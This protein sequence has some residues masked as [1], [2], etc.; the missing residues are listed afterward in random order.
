MAEANGGG[1]GKD[2]EEDLSLITSSLRGLKVQY[3]D[4]HPECPVC[5]QPCLQ[6]VQLP[7]THVFCFLCVKGFAYRSKKCALC[8]REVDLDY[9]TDPVVVKVHKKQDGG[10]RKTRDESESAAGSSTENFQWFYEGRNGW[11]QYDERASTLLEKGFNTEVRTCEIVIAGFAYVVD[12]ENMIQFRKTNP[13]RCRR[14]KRDRF[15]ADRKGV[16]GLQLKSLLTDVCSVCKK[17]FNEQE[18]R[19]STCLDCCR[20]NPPVVVPAGGSRTDVENEMGP[21]SG[22]NSDSSSPNNRESD[23]LTKQGGD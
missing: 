5:L 15:G 4:S 14:V 20:N 8:R 12:F 10:E 3:V 7:C 9:F 18:I 22:A 1:G 23:V 17:L 21:S 2:V 6:P 19:N 13:A 11:W 16:A